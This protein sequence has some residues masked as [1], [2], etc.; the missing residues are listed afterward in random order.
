MKKIMN[1]VLAATLTFSGATVMTSCTNDTSDNPTQEQAK[2]NRTEFIQHTRAMMKDLAENLNFN[3]WIAANQTNMLFNMYVL[4]NPYFEKS[5]LS[6]FIQKAQESIRPVEEGSELAQMG[7]KM[8]GTVDLTEFNYRFVMKT[9]GAGF[10]VE[11]ADD[12]EVIIN[13]VDP[14][15]QKVVPGSGKV[16]LSAGGDQRFK[17]VIPSRQQEGLA[18][19]VVIPSEFRFAISNNFRGTWID[20]YSGSFQ[21]QIYASAGTEFI[22]TSDSW[23]VSGTLKSDIGYNMPGQK[24]DQTTLNFSILSDKENK[25]GGAD[26]SWEQ[27]GRKMFALSLKESSDSAAGFYNLDLSKFTSASSIVDVLAAIWSGRSIDE[28]KLTLLDDLTTTFSVS[29]MAKVLELQHANA[30]ARRNYADQK[31]IDQYTQQLNELVKAEITCKGVNQT[32]PMRLVTTKFGVDWWSMPAFN[33]ADEN[34]YVSF[35][36]LLDPE[37]V[38]YGINIVDHAAEPMQ[39]SVIVVRQLIQYVQGLVRGYQNPQGK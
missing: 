1:W 9:E 15:T 16:A 10:D 26:L 39:Q 17:M 20:M 6:S 21:N 27:N 14:Q 34:G 38:T 33:F 11:E 5:V 22:K 23:R 25:K 28:A 36:D 29:D 19:V 32:I 2:K 12:F 35:V 8:F 31:T 7:F 3:S 13:G 30:S 18:I 24:I 37:S 4:N